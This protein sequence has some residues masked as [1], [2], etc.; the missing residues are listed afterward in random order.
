MEEKKNIISRTFKGKVVSDKMDKT[1]VVIVERLKFHKKYGKQYKESKKFKVHDEKNECKAG[2]DVLF[3]E[4]RPI[5]KEKRWKIIKKL[6][7]N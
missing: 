7:N 4:C 5:S 1:R 6:T 2:D 3:Q